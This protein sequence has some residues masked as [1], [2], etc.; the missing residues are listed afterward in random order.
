MQ[1][2]GTEA[3]VAPHCLAVS[4]DRQ[5]ALLEPSQTPTPHPPNP[6]PTLNLQTDK[7]LTPYANFDNMQVFLSEP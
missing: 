6:T 1:H 2:A 7:T 5:P 3:Q 4:V